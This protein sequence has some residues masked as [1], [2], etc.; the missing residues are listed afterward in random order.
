MTSLLL[1]DLN[2][3]S[4]QKNTRLLVVGQKNVLSC[5]WFQGDDPASE[6]QDPKPDEDKKASELKT[7]KWRVENSW[8]EEKD[9]PGYLMMT[10]NWFTEYVYEV[11][12]DKKYVPA[13]VMAV[14]EQDPVVLPAW[15][16]MGSL[17]CATCGNRDH[18]AHL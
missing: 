17:A 6:M 7:T 2:E 15:D 10:D 3:R 18:E 4:S 13:D 16:P 14:M 5:F 12:V 11:V 8:G 9:K 1:T